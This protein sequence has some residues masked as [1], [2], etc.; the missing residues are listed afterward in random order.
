[1]T[2][3]FSR[4]RFVQSAMAGGALAGLGDFGFL[5][6]IGPLSAAETK[7]PPGAVQFRSDIEPL[8]RVLETT[9]R[10]KLLEEIGTRIRHGLSYREVLTALLLG[11]PS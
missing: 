3:F 8:V 5:S 10:D 2:P 1:M 7:L 6:Q 11:W 4:R 9:P